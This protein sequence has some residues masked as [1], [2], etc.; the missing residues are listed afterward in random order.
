MRIVSIIN[1]KGGQNCVQCQHCTH[2][3]D[4]APDINIYAINALAASDD[5]LVPIDDFSIDGL[6]ELVEQRGIRVAFVKKIFWGHFKVITDCQKF[7]HAGQS[8]PAGNALHVGAAAPQV[9]VR[10]VFGNPLFRHNSVIR[11]TM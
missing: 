4:N 2:L 11:F 3:I 6:K 9:K 7:R 5:V 8:P 10:A 1:L